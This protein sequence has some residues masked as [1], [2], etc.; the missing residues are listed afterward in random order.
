MLNVQQG[1]RAARRGGLGVLAAA[2]LCMVAAVA[3]FVTPTTASATVYEPITATVPVQ[4]SLTGD[5]APSDETF[6]FT[7]EA[8]DGE[9]VKP[10]QDTL[11]VTGAGQAG[12]SLS[13]S[14]VGE[15]HYTVRQT[16]GTAKNWTYDGQVYSVTVYVLWNEEDDTIYPKVVV[17]DE[18][19]SKAEACTF[20]NAYKAPAAPQPAPKPEPEKKPADRIKDALPQTGDQALFYVVTIA[21]VGAAAVA[22]G[23]ALQ[24]RR[25][26]N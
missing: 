18:T 26:G 7:M 20:A 16:A 1:T 12:F 13:Y 24:R 14:E 15:H 6:T 19:G 25:E 23:M 8:A 4:V 3:L 9:A 10:A 21:V 17:E 22:G 11:T 5:K 2:A